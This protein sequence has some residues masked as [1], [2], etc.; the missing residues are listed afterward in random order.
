[1]DK[2]LTVPGAARK[3]SNVVLGTWFK[4]AVGVVVD[5]H[6]HRISRR[7]ELTQ[8]GRMRGQI[9][10]VFDRTFAVT[11]G[12]EA[13]AVCVAILGIVNA[14][15]DEWTKLYY[16]DNW[17][18]VPFADTNERLASQRWHRDPEDEHLAVEV[19]GNDARVAP[20]A[21]RQRHAV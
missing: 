21:R 18:T 10:A 16:L 5:T 8:L 17:F 2:L 1:M 7:L 11:R 19:V 20:D 6:V 15:R 12:L 14:Y 3:T 13:I 4:K 9:L